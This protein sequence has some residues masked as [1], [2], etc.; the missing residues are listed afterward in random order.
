M[1]VLTVGT[2]LWR[3]ASRLVAWVQVLTAVAWLWAL[4]DS[5][6]NF[7][8]STWRLVRHRPCLEDKDIAANQIE[9]SLVAL[10]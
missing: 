6:N 1:Q 8:Q 7:V 10:G 4:P 3:V 9:I 5:D 2:W